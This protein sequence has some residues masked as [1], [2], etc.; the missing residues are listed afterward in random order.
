MA[1]GTRRARSWSRGLTV[2][3]ERRGGGGGAAAW[4][5]PD[6]GDGLWWSE[7]VR[8]APETWERR[9]GGEALSNRGRGGREWLL[10][11]DV[12][13]RRGSARI[14]ARGRRLRPPRCRKMDE[15]EVEAL[16]RAL[17]ERREGGGKNWTAAATDLL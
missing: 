6:G 13:R 8:R 5:R 7:M 12:G 17:G 2:A 11:D 3:V 1:K 10:T 15:G 4:R 14:P 9:E 16:G